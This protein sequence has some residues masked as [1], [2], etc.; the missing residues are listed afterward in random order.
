MAD[1]QTLAQAHS[2][3]VWAALIAMVTLC[4]SLIT[5]IWSLIHGT[6]KDHRTRLDAGG[7][8][9]QEIG[10]ELGVVKEKLAQ[11]EKEDEFENGEL[12]RL[13]T[14]IRGIDS[15]LTTLEAD[16]NSCIPRRIALRG[17]K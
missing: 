6:I 1:Q 7:N 5:V 9:F 13:D 11:L 15:R 14:T 8:A 4:M 17:D 3:E 12:D 2:K 16:H 10:I